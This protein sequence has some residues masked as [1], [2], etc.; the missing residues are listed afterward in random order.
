[1][2]KNNKAENGARHSAFTTKKK[3]IMVISVIVVIA[4]LAWGVT[5]IYTMNSMSSPA[6]DGN[7]NESPEILVDSNIVPSSSSDTVVNE[8][9]L[10]TQE[11]DEQLFCG[12]QT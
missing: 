12:N 9:Q 4:A 10:T 3:T 5:S 2:N 7:A 8:S 6:I 1:L 11:L